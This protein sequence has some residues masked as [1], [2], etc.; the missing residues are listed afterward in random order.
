MKKIISL[1]LIILLILLPLIPNITHSKEVQGHILRLEGRRVYIDLGS[2]DGI[3]IGDVIDVI[4]G[5][6]GDEKIAA[7]IEIASVF[8]DSSMG[9][10]LGEKYITDINQ[11]L[12]NRVRA[13]I[14]NIDKIRESRSFLKTEPLVIYKTPPRDTFWKWTSLGVSALLF[15]T[16]FY[17]KNDADNTYDEYLDIYKEAAE[18]WERYKGLLPEE[19]KVRYLSMLDEKRRDTQNKDLISNIAFAT[20]SAT[21]ALSLYFFMKPPEVPSQEPVIS[22]KGFK[23]GISPRNVSF[24][25]SLSF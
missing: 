3:N 19:V 9:I 15:G 14:A 11:F 5:T 23:F 10:L 4:C 1:K 25:Y 16:G 22:S 8:E 17:Y 20:G 2:Q 13:E 12:S 24:S 18:E 6:C 7:Q 21:L